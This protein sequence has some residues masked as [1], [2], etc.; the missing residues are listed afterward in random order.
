MLFNLKSCTFEKL[1]VAGGFLMDNIAKNSY[2]CMIN[3]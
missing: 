1:Y 3:H 2:I